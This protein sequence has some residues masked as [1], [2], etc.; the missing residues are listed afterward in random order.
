MAIEKFD[1]KYHLENNT[2]ESKNQL[3]STGAGEIMNLQTK[4]S[5][6]AQSLS[7]ENEV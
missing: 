2:Y 4:S 1:S 6:D 3:A 7:Y 5:I